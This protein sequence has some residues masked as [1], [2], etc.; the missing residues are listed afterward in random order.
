MPLLSHMLDLANRVINNHGLP[1]DIFLIGFKLD[2]FMNRLNMHVISNDFCS[3]YM[4]RIQHWNT[5][6]TELFIT[7]P[8]VCALLL[9][10]GSIG[11]L[12]PERVETLSRSLPV[13]C[14]QCRFITHNFRK[15]KD[16]LHEHW[17]KRKASPSGVTNF[18]YSRGNIR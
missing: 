7:Y 10:Q 15:F 4:R 6:N 17:M 3:D 5:F 16:H 8:A 2:A 13:R 14:N 18:W 9:V 11:S 12:S 1:Q